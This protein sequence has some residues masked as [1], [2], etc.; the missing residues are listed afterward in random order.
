MREYYSGLDLA[1]DV[2]A[3]EYSR[4]SITRRIPQPSTKDK[5]ETDIQDKTN[6]DE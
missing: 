5:T 1:R 3:G 4:G 2:Y 6:S